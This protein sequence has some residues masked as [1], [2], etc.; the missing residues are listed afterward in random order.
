MQ[1]FVYIGVNI[2][3]MPNKSEACLHFVKVDQNEANFYICAMD[4]N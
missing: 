4:G 1:T 3:G 2:S